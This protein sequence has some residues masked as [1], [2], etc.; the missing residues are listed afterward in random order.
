M[1]GR[2]GSG[3][4]VRGA[5][6]GV[7][8]GGVGGEELL[9]PPVGIGVDGKVGVEVTVSAGVWCRWCAGVGMEPADEAAEGVVEVVV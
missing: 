4:V 1:G 6:D 5:A 8:Q 2:P 3:A 9:Q 7:A